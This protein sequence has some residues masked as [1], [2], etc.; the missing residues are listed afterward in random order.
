MST[1]T[2][3]LAT[4]LA[5]SA[6]ASQAQGVFAHPAVATSPQPGGVNPS[7]FIVG[8]PASP[9]W[10]LRHANADHPAIAT[11]RLASRS[12]IDPNT[13]IVQPPA[14]VEWTDGGDSGKVVAAAPSP[15]QRR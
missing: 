4:V 1:R 6:F 11:H 3:I 7:T 15:I 13:F 2:V 10:Q 12:V 9:T 5:A 8:H 14:H